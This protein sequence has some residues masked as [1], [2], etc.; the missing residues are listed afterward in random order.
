[1]DDSRGSRVEPIRGEVNACTRVLSQEP[2]PRL[3]PAAIA[4]AWSTLVPGLALIAPTDPAQIGYR[5]F[6]TGCGENGFRDFACARDAHLIVGRH[7]QADVVLAGDAELSLRH[8]LVVPATSARGGAAVRLVDLRATVPMFL[9]DDSPQR[10]LHAEGPFAVRLGRYVLGGFPIG[11]GQGH[12][13]ADLPRPDRIDGTGSGPA[14]GAPD[15]A[16]SSAGGGP[17]RAAADRSHGTLTMMPRAIT[18]VESIGSA[19]VDAIGLL[20]AARDGERVRLPVRA[21][22]LRAGV[23]VGRADKCG[24]RG[25]RALL[26][27][28]VS[29]VHAVVIEIDGRTMLY[30]CASTNGTYVGGRSIRSLALGDAPV[31]LAGDDGVELRWTSL[32][33]GA[34]PDRQ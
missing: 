4:A 12:P 13:P 5:L 25:L 26:T 20:G 2:D 29:R 8:L 32:D 21:A 31:Q 10:S 3:G 24:D 6:W 18:M 23:L 27:I 11:P 14:A 22:D 33:R 30:D 16:S 15:P 19:H 9:D 28:R 34:R 7:A 1:M 17:Y